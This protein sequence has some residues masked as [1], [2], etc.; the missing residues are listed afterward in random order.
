[1]N[2]KITCTVGIILAVLLLAFVVQ[3]IF[4]EEPCPGTATVGNAAPTVTNPGLWNSADTSNL[5][6]TNLN[7]ETEY[8]INCTG[9][10][11]NQLYN[12]KNV[13][14][15]I[16]ED[17]YA[18]EGSADSNVTHYT[19]AYLNSSDAFDEIGPDG[20]S[21]SHLVSG[22][23]SKPADRTQTSGV[24]KL[25]WKL[26]ST[27]NYT[28]TKTWKI[29]IIAYDATTSG[30]VQTLQFGIT[31]Y[32]ELT[33]NDGAHAWAGLAPGNTNVLITTPGDGKIDVTVTANANFDIQARGSADLA[34]DGNTIGLGNVTIHK[35]TLGSSIPLT[36]EHVDIGGLTNLASG[37]DQAYSFKLWID[38]PNGTSDGEYTYT[39]YVQ[40]AIQS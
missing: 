31:F 32:S 3:P 20:G 25:A 19:F 14:F 39:L 10:D 1:M 4:A 15:I 33:I 11:N 5:N 34:Y 13:T 28:A 23:C 18:D 27:G 26:H 35:D 17:T 2:K 8:H 24:Y 21:N 37:E 29:K 9:T 30:N 6:N 40:V 7:V 16:W 12:L 36:T 38:V 22:S